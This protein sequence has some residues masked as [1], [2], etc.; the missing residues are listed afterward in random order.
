MKKFILIDEENSQ[1]VLFKPL[2]GKQT[3]YRLEVEELN[4]SLVVI[5][6]EAVFYVLLFYKINTYIYIKF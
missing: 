4:V 6:K 5:S 1:K 3:G 2:C